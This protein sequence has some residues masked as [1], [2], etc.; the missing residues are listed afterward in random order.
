MTQ[1]QQQQQQQQ[2]HQ[3]QQQQDSEMTITS[4]QDDANINNVLSTVINV[5]DNYNNDGVNDIENSKTEIIK[6]S[7]SA[8]KEEK[9]EDEN[10]KG[11]YQNVLALEIQCEISLKR[12]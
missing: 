1:H 10:S 7:E 4:I 11:N 2:Q 5:G 12:T 9:E 8:D 6:E 3:Q